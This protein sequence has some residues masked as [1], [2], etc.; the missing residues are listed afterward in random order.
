MKNENEGN[1]KNELIALGCDHGGFSLMESIRAHFNA[2]NIKYIDFGVS[3]ESPVDYPLIAERVTDAILTG[4]CGKGILTC[5]TGIG[6]C[7]AANRKK[8]IRAALCHDTF[9]ARM[10]RLHNDA[11]ILT[12]GGRVIAAGLAIE[13]TETFLSTPFSGEE[14]HA[15][16]IKMMDE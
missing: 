14:R 9:S 6:M 15:N 13:I 1:D 2:K 5:G 3:S 8:G 16:R 4:K 11:N 10:T 7:M 12:M